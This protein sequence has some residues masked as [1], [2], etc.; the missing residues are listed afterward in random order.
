M[1]VPIQRPSEWKTLGDHDYRIRILEAICCGSSD[2]FDEAIRIRNRAGY[3]YGCGDGSSVNGSTV[4]NYGQLGT[5]ANFEDD[6]GETTVVTPGTTGPDITGGWPLAQDNGSFV[7]GQYF[8]LFPNP[9]G[10]VTA[11]ASI[12]NV[13]ASGIGLDSIFPFSVN[14]WLQWDA[15]S[16][17]QEGAGTDIWNGCTAF[18]YRQNGTA[19]QLRIF[20]PGLGV[21]HGDPAPDPILK[22]IFEF[23]TDTVTLSAGLLT[24]GEPLMATI[25]WD[26][27]TRLFSLYVN[28]GLIDQD[29][30]PGTSD[31][32]FPDLRIGS[33]DVGPSG[34]AFWDKWCGNLDEWGIWDTECLTGGDIAI[35]YSAGNPPLPTVAN[36]IDSGT[37]A[38]GQP[39][40]GDGLGRATWGNSCADTGV[41]VMPGSPTAQ[42]IVDALI[43]MGLVTQ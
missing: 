6:D 39:L 10:C 37:A 4:R 1:T 5:D 41:F 8:G 19:R 38:C 13:G 31:P 27:V 24:P 7:R 35:L 25:T 29:V 33:S 17:F 11:G 12:Y 32:T 18:G 22:A 42:D 40:C 3:W 21:S 9:S 23:S 43:A 30:F 15:Y 16:S 36:D 20:V 26:P 28:G 34:N 2:G 14:G